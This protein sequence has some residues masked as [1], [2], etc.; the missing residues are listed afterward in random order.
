MLPNG[1]VLFAVSMTPSY[2]DANGNYGPTKIYEYNPTAPVASSLT[3]VT[4]NIAA[5][6]NWPGYTTR[7]LVLPSGQV[8]FDYGVNQLY[9]YTPDGA[10]QAAWQPSVTS[11]VANGNNLYTLS[12]T[13]LN[14]LSA[15]A[16]YGSPAEMDENFPIVELKSGS[17][18]VYFARTF[19][20]SST[21]VA[22]G[23]TPETTQ[24][25]LPAN[26]PQGTYSLSVVADG[27]AS[28]PISFTGGFTGADLSV[29]LTGPAGGVE[30][31]DVT[32]NL[33]V[34]NNGPTTA[35]N[36]VLIDTL[37]GELSYV[38]A[39]KSQGSVSHSG[40]VVKFSLG[41]IAVGQTVT[42]TVTAQRWRMA[43]WPTR[44]R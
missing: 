42:A 11:V 15:G 13:Q 26:L 35:A 7:M 36:V 28:Q 41:S 38:S 31:N 29:A 30:G 5:L 20:W 33:S 44:H 1:D 18:T 32:Y 39:T 3:D 6:T 37:D 16:S 25:S 4:P 24:F 8:L 34:T 14:G 22:T 9:A 2:T 21:G 10:P 43:I 17:G 19:N 27:I 40:S 23:S 12:G